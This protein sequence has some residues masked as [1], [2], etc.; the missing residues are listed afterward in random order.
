MKTEPL[1]D[2]CQDL[3]ERA[4]KAGADDAEAVV[5]HYRSVD[6][7]LENSDIHTVQTTE[8][9]TFGLRVLA[10]R[11]LGFVTSNRTSQTARDACVAEALAQAKATPAD[12][13][14]DLPEPQATQPVDGLYDPEVTELGAE[15][16]TDLAFSLLEKVRELDERIRIDSGAVSA[17]CSAA[18]LVSSRGVELCERGTSLDAY[19]FGMAVD[20][21]EVASFDYDGEASRKLQGFHAAAHQAATRFVAKCTSGLG[22]SA[23]KS[24]KGKILLSP[25]AVGEF[26]L[27][28]FT[29]AM[30]ADAVRKGRSPLADKLGAAVASTVFTL[31]DDGTRAGGVGSSA[32]DREGVPIRRQTLVADG[33]LETFLYNHYE[34]RAAGNGHLS[35]GHASGGAGSLPGIGTAQLEVVA[36]ETP[37]ADMRLGNDPIV[38]VGRFSGSTSPVTGEFSGVVKNGALLE[39]GNSRPIKETMIAGNLYEALS[40]IV[41][42]STERRVLGGA[43]TLP[44][45]LIDGVSVTAG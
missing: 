23:G 32:F 28:N 39:G 40:R 1:I 26:L 15:Q 24:Y 18:A 43:H 17:S 31:I 2:L 38:Y 42:I 3:I 4:R 5:S 10:D 44:S 7:N 34:A 13:F 37:L 29:A 33:R 16:T 45:I 6:T 36:G 8:E 21:D 9:T 41:A 20:G 19:L 30:S 11:R 25:E 22:A 12:P 27:P 35:T 14:N